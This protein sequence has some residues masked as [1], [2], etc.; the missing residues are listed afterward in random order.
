[1]SEIIY[2]ID[3]SEKITPLMVRDAIIICFKQ[4]HKEILDMMDECTEWESDEER[5]KIRNLEIMSIIK[6][7][8]KESGVDFNNPTKDN[9]I[10]VM[11][12]LA[13]FALRFRGTD[14]IA[15]H[16]G[17]IKQILDKCE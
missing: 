15:K 5:E 12:N 9:L 10:K 4:A 3:L 17:E 7:A 6:N 16:Y 1:M 13:K 11:D 8:F 2:G 14:I